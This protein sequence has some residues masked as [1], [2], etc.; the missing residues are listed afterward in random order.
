[1]VPDSFT[2]GSSEQR[3]RWFM[4]GYQEGTLKACNTFG[5]EKL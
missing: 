2:T 5:A 3:K 1:V 4:I